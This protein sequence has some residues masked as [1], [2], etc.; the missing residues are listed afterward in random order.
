MKVVFFVN[1]GFTVCF[2][3]DL[4]VLLYLCEMFFLLDVIILEKVVVIRDIL[5]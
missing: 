5:V 2:D 3:K 1:S 4:I